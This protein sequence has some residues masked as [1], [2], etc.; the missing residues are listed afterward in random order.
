[1][2]IALSAMNSSTLLYMRPRFARA[3]FRRSSFPVMSIRIRHRQTQDEARMTPECGPMHHWGALIFNDVVAGF[4][5]AEAGAEAE[6]PTPRRDR[7]RDSQPEADGDWG[8]K[9]RNMCKTKSTRHVKPVN[10]T[11][12]MSSAYNIKP[13]NIFAKCTK[14]TTKP[15]NVTNSCTSEF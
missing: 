5:D 7:G 12:T 8:E 6:L 11:I 1:M 2:I 10:R 14:C 3:A 15:W 4:F 13:E 9:N